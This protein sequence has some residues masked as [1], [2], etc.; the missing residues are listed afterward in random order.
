M[1]HEY[2]HIRSWQGLPLPITEVA[3]QG[4]LE[5]GSTSKSGEIGLLPKL[6]APPHGMDG[7]TGVYATPERG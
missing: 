3:N 6:A 4:T 2:V 5:V 1:F 7:D